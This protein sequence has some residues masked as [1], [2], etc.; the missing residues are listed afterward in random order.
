MCFCHLWGPIDVWGLGFRAEVAGTQNPPK[1]KS[2]D[3]ALFE[4]NFHPVHSACLNPY[5]SLKGA[6]KGPPIDPLKEF[7]KKSHRSLKGTP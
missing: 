3:E 5:R 6:L 4:Q 7:L 1:A 2:I